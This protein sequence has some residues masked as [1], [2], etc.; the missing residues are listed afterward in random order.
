MTTS[1]DLLTL[2]DY[3]AAAQRRLPKRVYDYYAGGAADE[4]TV[5]EN[6]AAWSRLRLRPR[7]LVDVS[8][9]DVRTTVLG[10][11]VALPVLTAPCALNALAHPEGEL[12]VAR[13]AAEL[14][15]AQILSTVSAYSLE[16]VAAAANGLRWL[17]L[18]CYRDRG[19]THTL[20]ERAEAAGFNALCVTVDVPAP[21]LRERDLRN[22]FRVP[23]HIRVA[24]F[25]HLLHDFADGSSLLKYVGEQFDPALTWEGL[26]W[27]RS[28][29]QLPIV[30]KGVLTAEDARL[31]VQHGV[32]GIVVSNHGGRQL[33]SVVAT[34]HALPEVV[35]AVAGRVEVFVDGGVRRGTDVLKALALGAQAVLI[36]RPY[37]WGLAVEGEAGVRRVL[38]LLADDLCLSLALAGCPSLR[39]VSS[40][41]LAGH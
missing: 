2:K 40:A 33:D 1:P 13:A 24:N 19:L 4:I 27:L 37:L 32:A 5:R 21:G 26:D 29:T 12:A 31:A 34:A 23:A 17:Q 41:L 15:V 14:G 16:E 9:V 36:G 7:V 10:Q 8:A 38:Q 30:V 18:Y 39:A 22:R 3:E 6:E 20:V 28:F 25:D 11:P 35:E